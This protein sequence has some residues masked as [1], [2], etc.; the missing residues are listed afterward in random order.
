MILALPSRSSE[1]ASHVTAVGSRREK[2]GIDELLNKRL[3]RLEIEHPQP[4]HLI[5]RQTQP[6]HFAIFRL[7]AIDRRVDRATVSGCSHALVNR[8]NGTA[9][10][11]FCEWECV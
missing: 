6:G 8:K 3:T 4:P 1:I 10:N 2:S 5:E 11:L 9:W 7:N